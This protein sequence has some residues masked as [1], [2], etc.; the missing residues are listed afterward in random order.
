MVKVEICKRVWWLVSKYFD[1][2]IIYNIE[3]GWVREVQ[4]MKIVVCFNK[5]I[6]FYFIS[7]GNLLECFK[8]SVLNLI[9]LQL[10]IFV[11]IVYFIL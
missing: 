3:V 6:E 7:N 5:V 2:I 1:I 11:Y 4:V 9:K 8:Q 10:D